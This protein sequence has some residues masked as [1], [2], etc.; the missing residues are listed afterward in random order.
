MKRE[1]KSEQSY[2][3][4][5]KSLGCVFYAPLDQDNGLIDLISVTTAQI[6]QG[7]ATYNY[8]EG[9]YFI[10]KNST[11]NSNAIHWYDINLDFPRTGYVQFSY[12]M[13][14]KPTYAQYQS[15]SNLG[16]CFCFPCLKGRTMLANDDSCLTLN[17]WTK[18]ASTFIQDGSNYSYRY[19]DGTAIWS[20]R[21]GAAQWSSVASSA[22]TGVELQQCPTWGGLYENTKGYYK[23]IMIFNRQLT[24]Q[25]INE[26][27]EI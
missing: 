21:Y 9:C 27:Q 22:L 5:L 20:N 16:A 24:Q 4:W 6:G 26:I 3:D 23:N 17:T 2:I 19:K 11:L 25:E 13:E 15:S 14:L 18:T 1:H 12:L 8:T 10:E 7:S